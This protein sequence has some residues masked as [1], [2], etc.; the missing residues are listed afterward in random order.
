MK[1]NGIILCDDYD[2]SFAPGVK[3]AVDEFVLENNFDCQIICNKRF[4]KIQ[5]K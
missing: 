4:A 2:L 1:N 3:K 5:I